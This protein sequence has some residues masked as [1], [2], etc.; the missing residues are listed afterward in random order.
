MIALMRLP[1]LIVRC[2]LVMILA[3]AFG[4]IEAAVVV[5]LREIFHPD[6]FAFPLA[7]F[8]LTGRTNRLLLTE[9]AR[10]AAT[11]VLIIAGAW[12]SGKNSRQR[13]AFFMIIFALWDI[14]YYVFLKLILD[15]PASIMDWDV[16][17]LIPVPWAGP[18]LAPVLVSIMMLVF[19]GFILYRD[20]TGKFV[21]PSL[22]EWLCFSASVIL[23]IVSFCIAGQYMAQPDYLRYFSWAFFLM[24]LFFG[25]A[26]F[27]KY[28]YKKNPRPGLGVK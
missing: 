13:F 18:V 1:A 8:P 28:I 27:A 5:Y 7:Q 21:K 2:I 16:L 22:W 3:I 17:F 23:V 15:W 4:Y 9:V 11:L 6:G 25:G 19:A 10:E 14:F 24:G 26:L 20:Y 12:L